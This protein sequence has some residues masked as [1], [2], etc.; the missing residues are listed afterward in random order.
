LQ[1]RV[2]PSGTFKVAAQQWLDSGSIAPSHRETAKNRLN[3]WWIPELGSKEL[4]QIQPRDLRRILSTS[5][6]LAWK[7]R[8]NILSDCSAVFQT[9]L[10]D[11]LIESNPARSVVLPRSKGKA[12]PDPFTPEERERLLGE[13]LGVPHTYF[14]LG[15]YAGLRPGERLA[16]EWS[17]Y[18]GK[19]LSITKQIVAGR[20][21]AVTKTYE[22][23]EVPVV[24]P[25]RAA[26]ESMVR[27]LAGGPILV[28]Q[29]G[30]PYTS[31]DKINKPFLAALEKLS[32]RYRSPYNTR[33]TCATVMLIAGMEPAKAA[34]IMGHSTKMFLD[35]YSDWIPND[36][37]QEELDKWEAMF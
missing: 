19:K 26:L 35:T 6:H 33:H 29:Y 27:P 37:D 17:D 28:N 30:R 13:L 31:A 18:T 11:G 15:F 14:A 9:A 7:T 23:R 16:L 22:I 24:A 1:G 20:K 25:L 4:D 34:K 21:R 12:R 10:R 5:K 32:I 8:R 2:E 36:R 3:R